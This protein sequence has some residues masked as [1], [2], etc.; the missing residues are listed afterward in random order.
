[1]PIPF[2]ID[3]QFLF[4]YYYTERIGAPQ[5]EDFDNAAFAL[6]AAQRCSAPSFAN[7]DAGIDI[8]IHP[9]VHIAVYT[10]VFPFATM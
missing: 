1:M 10:W 4:D 2:V 5:A 8:H 9:H 7:R 6:R 3:S